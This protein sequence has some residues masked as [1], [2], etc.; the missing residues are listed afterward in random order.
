MLVFM[1]FFAF[2]LIYIYR[3]LSKN[4][5]N[6]YSSDFEVV[7]NSK[8]FRSRSDDT[9]VEHIYEQWRSPER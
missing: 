7:S 1:T 5:Q 6:C 4:K 9:S 8:S 2:T 3:L